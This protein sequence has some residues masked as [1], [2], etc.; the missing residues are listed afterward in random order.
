[1]SWRERQR[2]QGLVE[3]T[4]VVPLMLTV[5]LAVAELG[6]AFG[7]LHTVGYASREGSRVGS[8]L[9]SGGVH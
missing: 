1:M 8:A 5:V 9:A 2:G 4:M 7:D 3:F 6:L